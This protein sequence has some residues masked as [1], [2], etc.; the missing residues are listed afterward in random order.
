VPEIIKR[1]VEARDM[2]PKT[3]TVPQRIGRSCSEGLSPVFAA[4]SDRVPSRLCSGPA[5]KV[6][7]SS[8]YKEEQLRLA[9]PVGPSLTIRHSDLAAEAPVR[10][11]VVRSSLGPFFIALGWIWMAIDTIRVGNWR[12]TS[13]FPPIVQGLGDRRFQTSVRAL[14]EAV[15]T[16]H[17]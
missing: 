10:Q 14:P 7:L 15:I 3:G 5:R 6:F 12:N 2:T 9:F 1:L 11:R 13:V 17:P 4:S 16:E 8:D